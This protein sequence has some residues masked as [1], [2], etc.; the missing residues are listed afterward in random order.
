MSLVTLK[1]SVFCILSFQVYVSLQAVVFMAMPSLLHDLK[2][3]I[4]SLQLLATL[5]VVF[6]YFTSCIGDNVLAVLS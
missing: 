6:Y 1:L 2:S 5:W 4:L 3:F